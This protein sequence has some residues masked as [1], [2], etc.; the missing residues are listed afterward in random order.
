[1]IYFDNSATT[2][3]KPPAVGAAM[4]RAVAELGGNPGR[5]GHKMSVKAAEA[6]FAVR[7]KVAHMFGAQSE[8]VVFTLNCTHALNAAIKGV[9]HGS[10][11]IVISSL[12]HNSVARPVFA[13]EKKNCFCSIADASGSDDDI[14]ESFERLITPATTAVI[15]TAASNVTGRI[16]PVEKIAKICADKG[17]CMICDAAQAA[18][19]VPLKVGRDGNIICTAGHKGLYGPT[20]TGLLISDGSF[21]IEPIIQGGTGTASLELSQPAEIPESLESGTLNTVG[22]VA[23]GKGVDFV[24]SKGIDRIHEYEERLCRELIARI[25]GIEGVRILR[26]EGS[27]APIVAFNV[28]NIHSADAAQFLSE[29]GFALRGGYHCAAVAHSFL[30]TSES[31]AVRFSPSVFNNSSQVAALAESIKKLSEK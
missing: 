22:I 23:L 2:F 9:V 28:G 24:A 4:A 31:G 12:E 11:H 18:G 5:G 21:P 26:G 17:V 19:T 27:Y 15:C 6:I 13:L 8:N 1:M 14:A 25:S 16:M 3:P 7:E 30:G 29:R 20:G 10:E